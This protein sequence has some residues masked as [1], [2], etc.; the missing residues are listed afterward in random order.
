MREFCEEKYSDIPGI[1]GRIRKAETGE[2]VPRQPLVSVVMPVYNC[3]PVISATL[4]SVFAQ[5]FDGFEV[6]IV[7]DGSQDREELLSALAPFRD[8]IVY[9]E[10]DNAG[11]ASARNAAIAL[12][13]GE[14]LA[15][16]DADDIWLPEY[17]KLQIEFLSAKGLDMVYCDALLTGEPLY[18]GKRFSESAPSRGEVTTVSLI[19]TECNVITSGT[20]LR[21]RILEK[22]GLFDR[23]LHIMQDFDLWYRVAK[24]GAAIGYQNRVL[25]KYRVELSGLSG[26]SVERSF[27]NIEALTVIR[28]KYGLDAAE[29]EAWKSQ[30]DVFVAQYELE[31]GKYLMTQ[32]RF[33]EAREHLSNAN[34]HYHKVKISLV[35][36]MLKLM[37]GLVP[38][39]FK[40]LR[41]VEYTFI[42]DKR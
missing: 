27:R 18:D 41:P 22:V 5:E 42:A 4:E 11:A 23:E 6:V 7:N 32:G 30:M 3:A 26:S 10:Q 35:L 14:F 25:L 8:R 15:F 34:G 38:S 2:S 16:L 24:S 1:L 21:K 37:P 39:V 9:A 19:T 20:L 12:A 31:K 40:T 29:E 36:L 13:R 28:E 17:L 33:D